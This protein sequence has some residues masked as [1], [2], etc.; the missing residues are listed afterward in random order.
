MKLQAAIDRVSLEQM[1]E[2]GSHLN[3]HT[4]VVEVGTSL[5]KD[6]GVTASIGALRGRFP[7]VTI[8]ADIKTCDEGAYEFQR[9]YEAG[10]D[11]ATAMGF[12]AETTLRACAEVAASFGKDW[13]IDLLELPEDSI[14]RLAIAFPEAIFGVHLSFD[15][16]GAGLRELVRRST[17]VIRAAEA[18]DGKLRRI[19]VA[20]GV[21][22]DVL[23]ELRQCG[24][25]TV[26][27]GSAITK[28]NDISQAA[29]IFFRAC[30]ENCDRRN[31][32]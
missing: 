11:I 12:S 9:A 6:Y 15:K 2:L 5:I 30:H 25:D 32:K 21:K 24:I 29:E 13:F 14:Y 3:G 26:I 1:L 10:A 20:G 31:Q 16:Q 27:V 17:Q 7:D 23:P 28:A 4:D 22:L 19:A 18:A 8:L